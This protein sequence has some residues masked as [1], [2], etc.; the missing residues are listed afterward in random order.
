MSTILTVAEFT[1][2]EVTLLDRFP[3]SLGPLSAMS[4]EDHHT[5]VS[6]P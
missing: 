3:V 5:S 1:F 6:H 2:D 4:I